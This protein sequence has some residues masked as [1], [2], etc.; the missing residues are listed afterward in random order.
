ML[1]LR[2]PVPLWAIGMLLVVPAH[3]S[4][5]YYQGP[6]G[7]SDFNAAVTNLT[8]L[9][10]ILTF[11]TGD[12]AAGGL[13]NANGTGIN[14]LGFDDFF[15]NTPTDFTVLAG[16]LTATQTGQVT[17]VMFPAGGVYAFGFHITVTSTSTFGNWCIALT[18]NACTYNVVTANSSD[19]QFFGF[20]SDTPVSASLYIHPQSGGPKMV[21]ADFEA[22]SVPEPR[23]MLLVGLGLSILGMARWKVLRRA[24]IATGAGLCLRFRREAA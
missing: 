12:L 3:A 18:T 8:L 13:Y 7:E 11:S 15:F 20:V 4:T 5:S 22:Y 6:T 9:N 19:V 17:T 16:K 21:L 1:G 14:F 24:A 2:T 23:T 10:P